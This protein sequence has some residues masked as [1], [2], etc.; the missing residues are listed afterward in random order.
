MIGMHMQGNVESRLSSPRPRDKRVA[1]CLALI[2]LAGAG[3]RL[4]RLDL[5]EFKDDEAM[6]FDLSLQ[7]AR[8]EMF[9]LKGLPSTFGGTES[10][11]NLY[12]FTLPCLVSDSPLFCAG[13]VAVL[14]VLAI[15]LTY[16]IGCRLGGVRAGL[17]AALLF[18]VSPWAIAYS[19]KIWASSLLPFCGSLGLLCFVR[20]CRSVRTRDVLGLSAALSVMTQVHYSAGPLILSVPASLL[21]VSRERRR[22][23]ARRWLWGGMV[24]VGLLAPFL[25]GQL[26]TG[27]ADLRQ[28]FRGYALEKRPPAPMYRKV[29]STGYAAGMLSRGG[30]AYHLVLPVRRG[31]AVRIEGDADRFYADARCLPGAVMV[32]LIF[33]GWGLIRAVSLGRRDPVLLAP[34][35]WLLLIPAASLALTKRIHPH[36]FAASYPAQ[37]VLAGL[38]VGNLM[39]GFARRKRALRWIVAAA[40]AWTACDSLGFYGQFLSFIERSGG[41]IGEYGICYRLKRQAADDIARAAAGEPVA[42]RDFSHPIACPLAFRVLLEARGVQV[43]DQEAE[44]NSTFVITNSRYPRVTLPAEWRTH[45]VSQTDRAPLRLYEFRFSNR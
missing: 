31:D 4:H 3:V 14:N 30:F 5:M 1:V 27:F 9:R 29:K 39:T 18:A 8:G 16:H 19:R 33:L 34:V 2:L 36:Y 37:F 25:V 17:A 22:R 44:A 24:F 38:G 23:L 15:F 32:G 45:L 11:L 21:L 28:L 6:L 42:V 43:V 7:H 35:L 20:L 10:P 40:L 41:S 13:C 26:L 12:I